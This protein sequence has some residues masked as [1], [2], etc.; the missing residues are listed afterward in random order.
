MISNEVGM[1][2]HDRATRGES[3][4]LEERSQLETWYISQDT[5]ESE[6]LQATEDALPGVL[7]LKKQIDTALAHLASTTQR[8]QAI[9]LENQALRDEILVL[10]QQLVSAQ[11]A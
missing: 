6:Y 8:I 9:A 4:D 1:K 3:L 7:Q 10:Q 2:L 11:S 5:Q